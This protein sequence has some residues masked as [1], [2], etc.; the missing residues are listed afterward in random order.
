MEH[1]FSKKNSVTCCP[2]SVQGNR[3][4]NLIVLSFVGGFLLGAFLVWVLTSKSRKSLVDLNTLLGIR[5]EEKQSAEKSLIESQTL[6]NQIKEVQQETEEEIKNLRE[7][8]LQAEKL[9]SVL[10]TEKD[11]HKIL[12]SQ[13]EEQFKN[14]SQEILDIKLKQFQVQATKN[15]S[16]A[17]QDIQH[18]LNPLK[19]KITTFQKKVEDT[20]NEETRERFSL[21]KEIKGLCETHGQLTAE[22]LKLSKALKGD[23][24]A[25]GQWGEMVLSAVLSASGLKEGEHYTTQGK[26][27]HLK[28]EEGKRQKPDAIIKLPGGKH[29]VIDAKVSLTHYEQFISV[30]SSEQKQ[31]YVAQ[32]LHSLRSHIK[33]LSEKEYQLNSS[34]NTPNFVL[35]FFPIEG[36]FSL[37]LQS[38][39]KLFSYSWDRSI[40]I[41]SPTTLLATLKTVAFTWQR[42]KQNKNAIEIAQESGKLYDK[43]TL[44]T[45]SLSDIDKHLTKA[46]DSY[47]SA[48]QRLKDGKG[49]IVSRLDKIKQLGAKTSKHIS[50]DFLPQASALPSGLKGSSVREGK[51]VREDS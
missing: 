7:K 46:K 25:Q 8:L 36:A 12:N 22:T 35:M 24:K 23:V 45:E 49:S 16:Q 38:E 32:F 4:N 27:F 9:V 10:K 42:E 5:T 43:F 11:S 48:Q 19:E 30:D 39:P 26:D 20:Y 51:A 31:H 17:Q 29:I 1:E 28:D 33:Q 18:L 37:A 3:V 44:F 34:L 15:L 40:V 14:L 2:S 21:K 47:H 13:F 50:D 6:L 41:V